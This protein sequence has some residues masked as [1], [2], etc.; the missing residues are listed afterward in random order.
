MWYI[1]YEMFY[2]VMTNQENKSTP[3]STQVTVDNDA[4]KEEHKKEE[5]AKTEK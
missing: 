2:I 1:Y 4:K 3:S 5:P